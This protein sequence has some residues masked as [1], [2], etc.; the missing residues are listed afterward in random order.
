MN[1][2]PLAGYGSAAFRRALGTLQESGHLTQVTFHPAYGYEDFIEGYRPA[3]E[4][5]GG[6]R[7]VLRDGVFTRVC[8]AAAAN[9][10]RPYLL[11]IDEINR[12]DIPKI[13]G[14]LITLREKD[15]RGMH[16]TL[17]T[18]RRFAVPSNVHILGTMNTAD[19]SIRLLD[20]A[21]RRRFAF[22]ELLPD[23]EL[24][25]GNKVGDVDLGLLLR[26]LNSRVVKRLGR[27]RQIGHSFFLPGGTAVDGEA[28]LAAVIR[29][30]VLPLLQEYA[31]DDYSMLAEFVGGKIVD[32]QAHTV[33][34]LSD[35]R[36]VEALSAELQANTGD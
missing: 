34:G 25:D 17:P 21:L 6:L 23:T 18:G 33:A 11:L 29:T 22:H 26:E 7:L 24:L 14:E 36:L 19:R 10:E 30:E 8:E 35:E 1:L 2:E 13:L 27:E 15:K 9:P 20:S 5:G 12:G 16:I 4:S 28:E 32:E 31:Y 3:E